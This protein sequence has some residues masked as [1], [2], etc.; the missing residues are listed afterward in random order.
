MT[1]IRRAI[2]FALVIPLVLSSAA[3]AQRRPIELGI[4]AMFSFHNPAGA[5]N[6]LFMV[7]GPLGGMASL[8]PVN[9]L[10]AAFPLNSWISLE[11]SVGFN[12]LSDVGDDDDGE[13]LSRLG[14]ATSVLVH[15][16]S[17]IDRVVPFLGFGGNVTRFDFGDGIDPAAQF[18]AYGFVGMNVPV[19]S[20]LAFRTTLGGAHFFE[21][22]DT[23]E[24]RWAA[25]GTIGL[26]FWPGAPAPERHASR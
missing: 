17:A 21:D 5:D 8:T 23:F 12:L 22:E 26:S 2:G 10:R 18:G 1:R 20:R 4:D 24:A 19:A 13:T 16:S 11:P 25:F 7:E 3:E 15:R 6:N 14:F 9:G